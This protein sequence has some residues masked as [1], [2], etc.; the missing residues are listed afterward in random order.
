[1]VAQLTQ[2]EPRPPLDGA[3]RQAEALGYLR[4][5][6]AVE[7]GELEDLALL[8]FSGLTQTEVSERLRLPLGTVKGRA[9]LGLRKLR[10]HPELR[11]IAAG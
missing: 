2:P 5:R 4:L 9:R 1:M 11:G 6:Q 3:Q 7:V 8:H 10:G